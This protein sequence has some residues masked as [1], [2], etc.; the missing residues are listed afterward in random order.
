MGMITAES[1]MDRAGTRKTKVRVKVKSSTP[2]QPPADVK[3]EPKSETP[4]NE[5]SLNFQEYHL[6]SGG[7]LPENFN[8]MRFKTLNRSPFNLSATSKP[9]KLNR[10]EPRGKAAAEE[11]E[12][13]PLLGND[14]KPVIGQD[15]K[16]VMVVLVD[17]KEVTVAAAAEKK[18][19]GGKD[20]GADAKGKGKPFQKKTKQV[21]K[22]ADEIRQLRREERFPWVMEHD[23][24]EPKWVGTLND[25]KNE[26]WGLFVTDSQG[27]TFLPA[28][29]FYDFVPSR[30]HVAS[31]TSD[32]AEARFAKSQKNKSLSV[33][34]QRHSGSAPSAATLATIHASSQTVSLPGRGKAVKTEQGDDG[35]FDDGDEDY[36]KKES[37]Q[38]GDLDEMEYESHHADDEDG[39]EAEDD[40]EDDDTKE[41]NERLKREYAIAN[42]LRPTGV[43]DSDD[44]EEETLTGEGKKMRKA[45]KKLDKDGAYDSDDDEKNPYN[46]S[47]S[48]EEEEEVKQEIGV[49]QQP[50]PP[51]KQGS[52][53]TPSSSA[54]KPVAAAIP[55]HVAKGKSHSRASSTNPPSRAS[56]P[57]PTTGA[58][59]ALVA[60]RA[61]SPRKVKPDPGAVGAGKSSDSRAGSPSAN[62]KPVGGLPKPT[63]HK[64]KAPEGQGSTSPTSPTGGADSAGAARKKLKV[65]RTKT[66]PLLEIDSFQGILQVSEVVEHLRA[67]P[68][69]A[70]SAFLSHFRKTQRLKDKRNKSLIT[71]YIHRVAVVHKSEDETIRLAPKYLSAPCP[72]SHVHLYVA[73]SSSTGSA[74]VRYCQSYV[75]HL[76]QLFWPPL[77]SNMSLPGVVPT[78]LLAC[79][80]SSIV[81]SQDIRSEA[82]PAISS[83]ETLA[84]LKTAARHITELHLP[85]ALPTETVYG[86]GADARHADAVGRIFSTKGRP[87]DNPLIVHVSSIPM[88][89][90]LLPPSYTPSRTYQKLIDAFWPGPLTLL[91]PA[92]PNLV[93]SI[94]TASHPTVAIRMPSH[95]VARALIALSN[96]PLAAPSANSSGK[97]SPT[98]AAHVMRDLGGKVGVVLDGGACEVGLES[99]VVDGLHADGDVRVLRPGGVTVEDI[100]R[101]L[102]DGLES[103]ERVP[104][105]LVH[106]RD[107]QDVEME[108]A[109]TTPGMKYRHYAPSVPVVL[110]MTHVDPRKSDHAILEPL[111]AVLDS[112]LDSISGGHP[113]KLGALLHSDS[114]LAAALTAKSASSARSFTL[115]PFDLGLASDSSQTAQRLFDGLLTLDQQGVD[116]ILIENVDEMREGLA[117][118][119]RVRKAAGQT[120][121]VKI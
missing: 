40:I 115:H 85:V 74:L 93:P 102:A 67:N 117:V 3:V 30:S 51:P 65:V 100:E 29:H 33:Q 53:P 82:L 111:D 20:A 110:L 13:Y 45:L 105:V 44:E 64:R 84:S 118:M 11:S 59:A 75:Q 63:S 23:G 121:W 58:G 87:A 66:P 72:P 78:S 22:V 55:S 56:T 98:K 24:P 120:R 9:V 107:Y 43:D 60:Q 94:V 46:S 116:M 91:F 35:L 96:T 52:T 92:D 34:F 15:G 77:P 32:E 38:E 69:I 97:P 73:P 99:T 6:V 12:A 37:G 36:V 88:L 4:Q 7:S 106:R 104:R 41:L 108:A 48:E 50:T 31:M 17:G 1:L 89:H 81:F 62:A 103:G 28:H 49:R 42:K 83:A 5:A 68:G 71:N 25:T 61:M 101:V 76:K 2:S 80:P 109:P 14:G 95:P 27:F 86:L 57:L 79:D 113:I 114:P 47:D 119:N 54:P 10:K 19:K 16:P 21:F 112:L 8:I 26:A 18:A 39:M 90:S 70:S